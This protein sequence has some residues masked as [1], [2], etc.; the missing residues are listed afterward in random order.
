MSTAARNECASERSPAVASGHCTGIRSMRSSAARQ[1]P[2]AFAARAA[3]QSD[4]QPQVCNHW[5]L[6]GVAA[7]SRSSASST[8]ARHSVAMSIVACQS[9]LRNVSRVRGASASTASNS[10][11]GLAK[12][13]EV[14]SANAVSAAATLERSSRLAGAHWKR[15]TILPSSRCHTTSSLAC[16]GNPTRALRRHPH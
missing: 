6:L 9:W 7:A 15:R 11:W 3:Y 10:A 13:I 4:W 8:V 5:R 12:P 2:S 16:L 14:A 1:S